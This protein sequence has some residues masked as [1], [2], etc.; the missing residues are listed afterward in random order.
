MT[1]D[2]ELDETDRELISLLQSDARMPTSDLARALQLSAPTVNKR[3]DRLLDSGVLHLLAETDI[4][5]NGMDFL[6]TVGIRT[7]W[8]TVGEVADALA[9]LPETL[10]VETVAGRCDIEVVAALQ[11]QTQLNNFLTK[12]IPSIA[13]VFEQS[14]GLCLE[15]IKFESNRVPFAS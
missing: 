6:I 9:A 2:F 10:M 7:H 14:P 11:D 12:T 15:V 4:Q 1:A 8:A 5:A 13:G 3:L